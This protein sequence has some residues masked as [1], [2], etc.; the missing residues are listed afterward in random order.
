MERTNALRQALAPMEQ[1]SLPSN[2]AYTTLRRI[3]QEQQESEQRQ[4]IVGIAVIVAV[5]LLGIGLLVYTFGTTLWQSLAAMLRQ[6]NAFS[7]VLPTF[8]CLVFFVL[9]NL[10]LSR[11]YGSG[12]VNGKL[13]NSK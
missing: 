11:H 9:L 3:R 2:F 5:S 10:W 13:S 7:L 1:K 8:F 4:H 12:I 6:P